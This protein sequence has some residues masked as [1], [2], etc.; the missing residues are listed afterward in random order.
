MQLC[1]SPPS[2]I[3]PWKKIYQ[4][5]LSS[6][7]SPQ[8]VKLSLCLSEALNIHPCLFFSFFFY[9]FKLI[10]FLLNLSGI[11]AVKWRWCLAQ[12]LISTQ[13]T[14]RANTS[15]WK[16]PQQDQCDP[17]SLSLF[18]FF[19]SRRPSTCCCCNTHCRMGPAGSVCMRK[20]CPLNAVSGKHAPLRAF[21]CAINARVIIYVHVVCMVRPV[22]AW[23]RG[24]ERKRSRQTEQGGSAHTNHICLSV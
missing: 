5:P 16:V 24:S 19:S 23:L 18:I 8:S 6:L 10:V 11:N 9:F 20:S 7:S 13:L 14:H 22:R 12:L 2:L 17:L 15:V 1:K 21:T 4:S 3:D